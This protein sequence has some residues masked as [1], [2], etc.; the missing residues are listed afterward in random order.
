MPGRKPKPTSLKILQGTDRKDRS[1]PQEPRP[2]PDLPAPPDHLSRDALI[3]WGRVSSE[4][5]QLGLLTKVDR[6]ALAA[7]CET[8]SRWAQSERLVQEQGFT[9][10]TTNGNVIQNPMVGTANK[11]MELMHKYMVEFGMTPSSRTRIGA[12]KTDKPAS[13]WEALG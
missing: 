10:E 7:Y 11:A 4:L 8:Y 13:G 3:E 5:F 2:T 9:I 1:N 12:T 6:A